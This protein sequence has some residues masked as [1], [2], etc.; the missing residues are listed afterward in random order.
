MRQGSFILAAVLVALLTAGAVGAY[1]YDSSR[2]DVIAHG[3]S[4]G[5]V[6]L[7]GMRP[8]Q[9]RAALEDSVGEPLSRPVR[10]RVARADRTFK[11]SARRARVR[12][13]VPGM[14]A[15]ALGKS[16]E[17]NL[18]TRTARSLAGGALETEL[19]AR[20]TYS[21]QAVSGLVR[22]MRAEVDRPA[23]DAHVSF[24]ASSLN[25]VPAQRGM[26]LR[27][28]GLE[29]R[30]RRALVRPSA[31]RLVRARA[32]VVQP[33][34][35]SSQLAARYPTVITVDRGG[36]RLRLFK[37]LKEAGSYP[38]A[39]GQAGLETPAGL[40]SIQN[41]AVN[42]AWHVP[43]SDWAGDLAGKVI[44]GGRAD[45]P[46]KARWM[47]IYAGAGIHGTSETG[48]L[49]TNASHGCIRMSIPEVT[50]LYKRVEVGTPVY[51][52]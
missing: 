26:E 38:I 10:V 30:I 32:R 46:L 36:H 35:T 52:G 27:T 19:P 45:N 37:R 21:R 8:A 22:Y 43:N 40:Y 25:K 18:L 29:R 17:G 49:G 15:D 41:K 1:A 12:A 33:S 5:G 34:V 13:D 7:G 42:P 50:A 51:I 9:A 48:S 23:R 11:L 2:Q 20:V 4:V 47:G 24:A 31:N 39:V 14:V 3:V 6:D 16:R 28:R 44:P